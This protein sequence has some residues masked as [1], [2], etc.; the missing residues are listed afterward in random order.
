MVHVHAGPALKRLVLGGKVLHVRVETVGHAERSRLGH[1]VAAVDLVA[2]QAH[3]VER[4][5]VACAG[6]L[7]LRAV[8]LHRADPAAVPRRV[9][10]HLVVALDA[11]RPERAGHHG[12][13]AGDRED[14]VD[15]EAQR[16]LA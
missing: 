15:R 10:L 6:A 8:H 4:D 1:D 9:E 7:D 5:A 14:A 11:P 16:R 13:R 2:L 12:A 3:D